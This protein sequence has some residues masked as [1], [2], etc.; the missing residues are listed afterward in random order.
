MRHISE[1]RI[2]QDGTGA[3]VS[4]LTSDTGEEESYDLQMRAYKAAWTKCLDRVRV[5]E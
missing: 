4:M 5:S 2:E 3:E 1:L